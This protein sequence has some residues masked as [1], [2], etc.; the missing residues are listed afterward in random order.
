VFDYVWTAQTLGEAWQ[1][2][3]QVLHRVSS[4]SET[5]A[6][7][8]FQHVGLSPQDCRFRSEDT[9]APSAAYFLAEALRRR[10]AREPLQHI[11]GTQAFRHL[12][13]C[14]NRDVLIP[15][16]ETEQLVDYV[17][18]ACREKLKQGSAVRVLDVGTGSGAIALALKQECSDLEVWASD[19]SEP[20]LATARF[21]AQT[22]NLAVH[23]I[24]GDG[25]HAL[26]SLPQPQVRFDV[27]VS[28]PP[29]IPVTELAELEPEV[30]DYEPTQALVPPVSDP[31]YFYRHFARWAPQ[32]LKPC[33]KAFFEIHSAL[34]PETQAC[35]AEPIWQNARLHQDLQKKDRYLESELERVL[36]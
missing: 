4:E 26:L 21:N 35:F 20:A 24:Q 33:G 8:L 15:R 25:L 1:E 19:I 11:L 18:A 17:L 14:V 12:E 9:L 28:N 2:V 7:W 29:Y 36:E 23:F 13:L 5:E 22:L 31:L 3:L 10:L 27:L 16:P 34:G 32:V 6:R 30:R